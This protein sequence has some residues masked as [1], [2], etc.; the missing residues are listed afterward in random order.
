MSQR[1][2]T[3]SV[4]L[5]SYES[6]DIGCCFPHKKPA[7]FAAAK[8]G[9]QGSQGSQRAPSSLAPTELKE[10]DNRA[11]PSQN[12]DNVTRRFSTKRREIVEQGHDCL[13]QASDLIYQ[14]RNSLGQISQELEDRWAQYVC[15]S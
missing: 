3:S 7:Q 10:E 9:S 2:S 12:S 1:H 6:V 14:H 8:E 4:S 13:R 11:S 15:F 5:A